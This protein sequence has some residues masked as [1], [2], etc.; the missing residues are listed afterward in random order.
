MSVIQAGN[1]TTT[2]LV[3]RGDT[4][5]NLV[6]TTGGANTVALTLANT[7]AATFAGNVTI[8]GTTT[9]TGNAS[10]GNVSATV[11]SGSLNGTVGAT[12]ASTGAFTTLSAS[13]TV[14]GTG[15][16]TYLAS[17]PAIG[18]TAPSTGKFTTLDTT[19]TLQVTGA[20]T[21][22]KANSEVYSLGL[23]YNSSGGAFYIGSSNSAN[24][25]MIFSNAV[26]TELA[27]ITNSGNLNIGS[28]SGAA[29]KIYARSSTS[30][31]NSYPFYL[32]NSSAT[33]VCYIRS[34]G[35]IVTGVAANSPT[36]LSTG[37]AANMYVD[38]GGAVYKSTSSLKYKHDVKDAYYGLANLLQLRPV[39]YKAKNDG[40]TV[41]GG[42]IAEEVDAAGLKEFVAYRDGEPDAL[43][44]GNMVS[45]CIKAIQELNAKV[46]AQAAEIKSLKEK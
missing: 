29:L 22:L 13:S 23:Q 3:Y 10:F 42:L 39:T 27:R 41:F 7:Q 40:D 2:S 32:E 19:S 14:S 12:T 1:T 36:N 24:P 45:L 8:S 6:F 46:E 21:F 18:A 37:A 17:P 25:D 11:F 20:R 9:Q 26:G 38:G 4:T 34:D 44:Y 30:D 28:T 5:G 43:H 31:V 15:F 35:L 33:T 16:S